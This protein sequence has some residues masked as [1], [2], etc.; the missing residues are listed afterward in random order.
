MNCVIS[1]R[2]D[3]FPTL[4]EVDTYRK[5]RLPRQKIVELTRRLKYELEK[6]NR[7]MTL[8]R[9]STLAELW[10]KACSLEL[11]AN[12]HFNA[13]YTHEWITEKFLVLFFVELMENYKRKWHR[14]SKWR[15]KYYA[16]PGS[17]YV[18]RLGSSVP[19]NLKFILVYLLYSS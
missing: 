4:N 5:Y 19:E 7:W 2:L 12:L 18:Y 15:Q 17:H 13:L 10:R 11:T 16:N 1:N 9:T 8:F 6:W 3:L 14:K